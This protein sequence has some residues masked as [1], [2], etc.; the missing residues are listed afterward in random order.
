[1]EIPNWWKDA[2]E[3]ISRLENDSR[4]SGAAVIVRRKNVAKDIKSISY[5]I[6]QE[7]KECVV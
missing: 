2:Q 1:M 3:E 7:W 6:P 4:D 5:S